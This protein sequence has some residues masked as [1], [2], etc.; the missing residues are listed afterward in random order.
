[1][2]SL[3]AKVAL[4]TG[5]GRR[6]GIGSATCRALAHRGADVFFTYWK[7]Y[8]REAQWATDEDEPETL[9]AD[10][11]G[12]GVSAEG[13]ELDLSL[14]DSPEGL[15]DVVIE[16][17][18]PPFIL[19]NNVAHSTRDGLQR[20]DAQTLDAHYAVNL[21]AAALLSFGFARRYPGG[22]GGR[23][24]NLT[25]GQSL[26]TMPGELAYAATKGPSRP[27]PP[28]W[29]RRSGTGASPSTP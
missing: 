18:G 19:V 6:R 16:R 23:T 17:F 26:G 10:L 13:V 7:A 3:R 5:V 2:E 8:D 20:L 21:R 24:I 4:V 29:R 12:V 22:P 11:R 9:L 27:S 1:V 15:L 25:S 28:R 14:P